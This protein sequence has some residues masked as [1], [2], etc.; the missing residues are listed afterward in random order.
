MRCIL[1]ILGLFVMHV[2][3]A[4]T[5]DTFA[6]LHPFKQYVPQQRLD[7]FNMRQQHINKIGMLTITTWG[8]GN[9]LYGMVATGTTHGEAQVFN[10]SNTIWGTVNLVIGVPGILAAYQKQKYMNLSLGRTI[11]HQHAQEKIFLIN[12]SLDFV[13][14]GAGLAMWGFADRQASPRNRYILSGGGKSFLLQGS[15]LALFDWGMYIA[16]SQHAYRDLNRYTAGLAFTGNGLSYS[17]AF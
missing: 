13:Y 1:L 11:L 5:L 12:G 3:S 14:I 9:L 8:A 17:L 2:A 15:V 10:A 4:Q 16:H 6:A 7:S